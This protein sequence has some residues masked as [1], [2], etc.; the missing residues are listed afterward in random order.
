MADDGAGALGGRRGDPGAVGAQHPALALRRARRR[1]RAVDRPVPRPARRS[2]PTAGPGASAAARPLRWPASRPPAS[3]TATAVTT[4]PDA[5]EPDHLADLRLAG[6]RPADDEARALA[7]AAIDVRHTERG[8]FDD[9]SPVPRDPSARWPRP[10]EPSAA[11]SGWSTRPT[12]RPRSRSCSPAPT[13]CSRPTRRTSRSCGGGPAATTTARDGLPASAVPA[14]GTGRARLELPAARLRRRP[15]RAASRTG[16]ASRRVPSTRWSSCSAPT[17]T[18][19]AAWLAAGQALGRLLLTATVHGLAA[20]PM[21][22]ALEVPDTRS[23][24]AAELGLVG[25]PQMV[26]RVGRAPAGLDDHR[27]ARQPASGRGRPR[28]PLAEGPAGVPSRA[29]PSTL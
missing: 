14:D 2:T 9:S 10:C 18:S 7:A 12:T 11:G 28:T 24:L 19:P 20:S 27:G 6:P 1:P 5:A 26:L 3:V 25:H 15:R 4:A 29:G 21:T 22:Q 23:R 17:T 13:T 8:A 16:A